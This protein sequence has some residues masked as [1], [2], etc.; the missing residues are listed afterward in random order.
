MKFIREK[1]VRFGDGFLDVD[2]FER[3]D[4]QISCLQRAVRKKVTPPHI[5]AA[6]DRHSRNLLRELVIHNF[7]TGDYYLTPTYRDE[8]PSLEEAQ[9]ELNNYINRLKRLYSRHGV[10]FKAIYVTEGGREKQDGSH[11]R[12]HHHIV[13]NAGVPREEIE[14]A[15]SRKPR[16]GQT[17]KRGFCNSRV[18]QP[19]ADERGCEAIAE[20]IAKS[21]TKTL[22]KG[23]RRWNATR[24][25]KRPTVTI[26]DNKMSR[27]ATEGFIAEGRAY[28]QTLLEA[29]T[30]KEAVKSEQWEKLRRIL[31]KRY[32]R[33]LIDVISSVNPFTGGV[34]VSARFR[35]RQ[36]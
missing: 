7:G 24:N 2:L 12:V 3:D 21:R 19:A 13:C 16:K 33:E 10:E 25:I 23:V 18:I 8:P 9:R 36:Q 14:A 34:Y 29:K 4:G 6:N 31:E 27:R 20:Y 22:G 35:R 5:I 28:A 11:T 26:M 15:W 32:D 17:V 1:K 30:I